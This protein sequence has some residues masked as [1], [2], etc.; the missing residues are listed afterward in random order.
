MPDRDPPT[1]EWQAGCT[2]ARRCA[3]TTPR[4]RV[5]NDRGVEYAHGWRRHIS[6]RQTIVHM[7]GPAARGVRVGAS[8]LRDLLDV[9]VDAVQQSVRVRAEGRSRAAGPTPAWLDR[10]ATFLVEIQPGSTRMV[11]D[12]QGLG[13]L[14][15][16]KFAR[17]ST[18]EPL[19]P[20]ATCL[21][22]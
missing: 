7:T 19:D 18:F 1:D 12:A 5:G 6:M 9:L 11:L 21:D 14:V 8:M 22:V 17:L 20:R 16:D 10:A 4:L 2:A 3:P 13:D 15:P